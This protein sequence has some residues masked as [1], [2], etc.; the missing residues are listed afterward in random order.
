[1]VKKN[2]KSSSLCPHCGAPKGEDCYE[3]SYVYD[4]KKIEYYRFNETLD[5]YVLD[6]KGMKI[7]ASSYMGLSDKEYRKASKEMG[8]SVEELRHR[9]MKNFEIHWNEMISGDGFAYIPE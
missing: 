9:A 2:P 7:T 5:K 3:I 1:M 4:P 8:I 6:A